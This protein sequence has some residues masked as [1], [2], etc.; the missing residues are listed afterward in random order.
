MPHARIINHV[1]NMRNIFRFVTSKWY[2]QMGCFAVNV[3]DWWCHLQPAASKAQTQISRSIVAVRSPSFS[4]VVQHF[5]CQKLTLANVHFTFQDLKPQE[6][7][8][9]KEATKK[10]SQRCPSSWIL[11]ELRGICCVT[12][13]WFL[14]AEPE[15]QCCNS[16]FLGM[17]NYTYTDVPYFWG[18]GVLLAVL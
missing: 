18:E 4:T 3:F 13:W 1:K 2:G 10:I 6:L 16:T 17:K 7:Q 12:P 5:D 14:S 8:W 11:H 15:K 9:R